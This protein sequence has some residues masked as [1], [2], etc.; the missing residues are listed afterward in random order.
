MKLST[1]AL[2][3]SMTEM[4]LPPPHRKL[5]DSLRL[6]PF[7][8]RLSPEVKTGTITT[9]ELLAVATDSL[10]QDGILHIPHLAVALQH[11]S[12]Q[13]LVHAVLLAAVFPHAGHPEQAPVPP[14]PVE[15]GQDL[16]NRF[17]LHHLP[18]LQG[19]DLRS[20]RSLSLTIALGP[21]MFSA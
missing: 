16:I 8:P 12:L 1:S 4:S 2:D 18:R 7:Q 19:L 17:H 15:G 13:S 3:E 9:S 14:V 5:H 21:P 11:D 6:Y 10:Q 20:C